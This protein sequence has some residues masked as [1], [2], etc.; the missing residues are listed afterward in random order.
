VSTE[1]DGLPKTLIKRFK[2]ERAIAACDPIA[3]LISDT[4]P[5]LKPETV[6]TFIPTATSRHRMRGY[7]QSELLAKRIAKI[8]GATFVPLLE[9][10][11]QTRQVGS[12]KKQRIIQASNMF[13][14]R[15]E[16]AAEISEVIIIDDILTTGASLEAAA[17]LLKKAGIKQVSAA[18]FAQKH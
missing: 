7:D 2:F 12:T 15:H 5:Y 3:E 14:L 17:G 16:R 6:I 9:R 10:S 4:L 13:R 18:V 8:K 11:S 1:Y